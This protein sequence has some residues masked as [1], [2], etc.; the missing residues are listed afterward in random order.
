M[1][2]PLEFPACEI[3]GRYARWVAMFRSGSSLVKVVCGY[4]KRAYTWVFRL[5]LEARQ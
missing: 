1:T 5:V 4:H 2:K 3:C